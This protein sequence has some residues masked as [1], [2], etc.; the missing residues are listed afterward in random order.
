MYVYEV[1]LNS[2]NLC[3]TPFALKV[4]FIERF[5]VHCIVLCDYTGTKFLFCLEYP[6]NCTCFRRLSALS[7][8]VLI[9]IH[10][11]FSVG[12]FLPGQLR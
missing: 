2:V 8:R 6:I 3:T 4:S 11:L 9:E 5:T 12:Y 7:C 1:I 10:H